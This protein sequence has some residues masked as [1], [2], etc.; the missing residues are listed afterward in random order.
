M[1]PADDIQRQMLGAWRMMTGRRDG[2]RL[3]DLSVDGFWN[4]FFAIIVAAPVLIA[5]WAPMAGELAG[6]DASFGARSL[7]MLRL[8][9]VDIGAWVLP[10]AGLAAVAGL[11]GIRDRFVH[12]VVASNWGSAV[13]A[14]F[15]LPAV[16]LRLFAP[17]AADLAAAISLGIFLACLVLLWRLTNAAIDRGAGVATGVFAGMLIASILTLLA[18]QDVLGVAAV[19]Q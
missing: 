12:Y 11:A 8:A 14:W 9:L 1:P 3:L 4:S 6:S 10:I 16:L 2:M 18:L 13:L 5:G 19:A 15:M 17:G 7:Y